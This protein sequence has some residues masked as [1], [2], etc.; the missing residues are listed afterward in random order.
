MQVATAKFGEGEF[1]TPKKTYPF[2]LVA[3]RLG[4]QAAPVVS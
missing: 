3:A 2:L 1:C 4:P